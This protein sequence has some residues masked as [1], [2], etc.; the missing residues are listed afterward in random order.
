[1]GALTF[2]QAA[3]RPGK[4]ADSTSRH[5]PMRKRL[6]PS[7]LAVAIAAM[8]AW[9]A[10]EP[11]EALPPAGSDL[12]P[13]SAR[14]DVT[15]RLGT[16]TVNLNG[17]VRVQ[18]QDP[19]LEG[20]VEVVDTEIV[21]MS[22]I[23]ASQIGA[24]SV[25][26]RSNQASSYVSSG[27]I[28]S[29]QPSAQFPATSFF[30]VYAD[31]TVPAS[32]G[33]SAI[34][35]NETPLHMSLREGGQ[36]AAT[37]TWPPKGASYELTP[38]YG[39]DNDGDG[40]I[41]EDSADDDGDGLVD[42]DRLG[43][44]PDTPGA[45]SECTPDADC[46][47]LDG[48]DPPPALCTPAVCDDDSDG[49]TDEDLSCIPLMNITNVNNMKA[50]FCVRNLTMQIAPEFASF[51]VA[52]GGPLARH[53]ADILALAA[54]SSSA[55]SQ[56]LTMM[57]CNDDF[58]GL[59]SQLT[60]TASAGVTYRVQVGGYAG[61][62]PA[63]GTLNLNVYTSPGSPSVTAVSGN[64]SLANAWPISSLPF[65]GQQ[66]T[67]SATTEANEPLS[68]N[69]PGPQV[70]S[71]GK[72]VWY[73]Y[74]PAAS[75]SVTVST[76]G[77][78]YDTVLAVYT[79]DSFTV[80]SGGQVPFVRIPCASLG[81]TADGCDTTGAFDDLD[82]LS[83]G[84]DLA[85]PGA[86]VRFSVAAGAQGLPGTAVETQRNCPAPEPEPDVFG[87]SYNATNYH[88]LDGNG[89]VGACTP[90]FPLGLIESQSARDDLDALD[91]QDPS[92]VDPDGDGVPTS[93]VY[94]S[95]DAVSASLGSIGGATAAAV[96]KT[97]NG[98]A[99]TVYATPTALGLETGDDL[100]AL[101]L[102]E[103]GDGTFGGGDTLY[104]SLAAG[105]PTLGQIG[106]Q[107]GDLLAPGSPNP[108]VV[109]DQSL[110]GLA[111]GDDLDAAK[112]AAA[113]G[114]SDVSA[115]ALAAPA[116]RL[117]VGQAV[118]LKVIERVA[119]AGPSDAQIGVQWD[120]V[121]SPGGPSVRWLAQGGDSC[122]NNGGAVACGNSAVD[123]LNFNV[124]AAV[125]A[126]QSVIRNLQ[127]TCNA[128]GTY[129]VTLTGALS[130]TAPG[131]DPNPGDNSA[132]TTVSVECQASPGSQADL[133]IDQFRAPRI[134]PLATGASKVVLVDP[135]GGNAG[136]S[137]A[138]PGNTSAQVDLHAYDPAGVGVR[139]FAGASDV[140]RNNSANVAC[141]SSE[142][143]Q[144][145][146]TQPAVM[147]LPFLSERGL[148]VTCEQNGVYRLPVSASATPAS[149][150]DPDLTNNIDARTVLLLCLPL[151]ET[152]SD[153]DSLANSV[154]VAEA[155]N[156]ANADTDGD[157][158][159]DGAD[160][161]GSAID[162]DGDSCTDGQEAGPSALAGGRRN[163]QNPFDLF[164]VPLPAG[165]PGTGA[166]DERVT[167]G[168]IVA[169][170][171]KFGTYSGGPPVDNGQVYNS[172]F[173]RS[174]RGP[175]PNL[176]PAHGTDTIE[177]IVNAVS[178]F[179][180]TC[181]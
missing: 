53:P 145:V 96:L 3:A 114:R 26:E 50:G 131:G 148:I 162:Y 63:S 30:D 150:S 34:I 47:R 170:V 159:A 9:Q 57:A 94:F 8:T 102:K 49:Q 64:D 13:V 122:S 98:A 38:I 175:A 27:E 72:T 68:F 165:P 154:E 147:G 99:P 125:A 44:D 78:S 111:A 54:A 84:N 81:L 10:Q 22:L 104:F 66:S 110:L 35:H 79:G 167:I 90:A 88:E 118:A 105:S 153:D 7:V 143:D 139:W 52:R 59:Q 5:R 36:E 16:D 128:A 178:Q 126:K 2:L 164:D 4:R 87:S 69:C 168:D 133:R 161:D 55:Q 45:G 107:A 155:L 97:V 40:R 123:R 116:A 151:P 134:V 23:G 21:A 93:P 62:T 141:G 138:Y 172:D 1:M 82:A 108:S 11:V 43:V 76:T 103:S 74:T 15:S 85:G 65:N 14:T 174:A 28:R 95:L 25:A 60:F 91:E 146:L 12:L 132:T 115:L 42:E 100:D 101:C 127:L 140:C 46:D 73:S 156:A 152:D 158:A 166:R 120:A 75:G 163:A 37:S 113:F 119:N 58:S 31:V 171:T 124:P 17:W 70:G 83:Y 92:A 109:L 18:R 61:P 157:G 177:D 169:V 160:P 56:T 135:I 181:V 48:E 80:V 86:D 142:I 51:S 129:T 33:G 149:L 121:E 117:A 67:A 41:D 19:H 6:L 39:V 180:N 77:S 176:G 71:M 20:G 136:P 137:G 144:L 32:P 173:D 89:P 130:S 29:L 24:V 179:G 112:C 106:A